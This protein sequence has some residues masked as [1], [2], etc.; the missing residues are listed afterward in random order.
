MV[1][2]KDRKW[3]NIIKAYSKES[4]EICRSCYAELNDYIGKRGTKSYYCFI[5]TAAYG[6]PS[7]L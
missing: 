3:K 7:G 5:A 2:P 6:S 4:M 1:L